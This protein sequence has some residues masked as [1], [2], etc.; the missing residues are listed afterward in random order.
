M[1]DTGSSGSDR[2]TSD[3]NTRDCGHGRS[4]QHG[5]GLQ[6]W[7][8]HWDRRGQRSR[9]LELRLHRDH[10]LSRELCFQGSGHRPGGEHQRRLGDLTVVVDASAP[11]APAVTAITTDAGASGSDGVTSDTTLVIRGHGR[12]GEHGDGLQGWHEHRHRRGQRSRRL[13]LR[14]HRDHPLGRVVCLQSPRH[15]PSGEHQR[16]LGRLHGGRRHFGSRSPSRHVD[17]DGHRRRAAATGS[18]ATPL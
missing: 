14:L 3:T 11:A 13:E 10:P 17:H 8:E 6:G 12:S 1:T 9:R 16:R 7:H 18:P 2:V 4:G 5:D 15:R